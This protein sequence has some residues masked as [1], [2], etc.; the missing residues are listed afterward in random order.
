MP[1]KVH[2]EFVSAKARTVV[3]VG[4]FNAWSVGS[5]EM[6]RTDNGKWTK[7]LRLAPGTYEYHFVVDGQSVQDPN[8]D[9]S[10]INAEGEQNSLLSVPSGNG[11]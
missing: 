1:R 4:S 5:G 2:F 11:N 8:A 3:V 10:V 6:T 9:H 7:D